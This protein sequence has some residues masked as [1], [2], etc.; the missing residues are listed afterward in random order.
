MNLASYLSTFPQKHVSIK[1]LRGSGRI[2]QRKRNSPRNLEGTGIHHTLVFLCVK[3]FPR[4]VHTA[5]GDYVQTTNTNFENLK[6]IFVE[7]L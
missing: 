6:H 7:F 2:A 1:D 3:I 5:T 4:I